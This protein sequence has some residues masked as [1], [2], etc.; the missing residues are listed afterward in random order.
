MELSR[1]EI[2]CEVSKTSAVFPTCGIENI[3]LGTELLGEI[4]IFMSSGS[5]LKHFIPESKGHENISLS[6]ILYSLLEYLVKESFSV[7]NKPL[8]AL[9]EVG[10]KKSSGNHPF[11]PDNSS[12]IALPSTFGSLGHSAHGH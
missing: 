11:L 5:I 10:N 9:L 2:I 3:C 4:A 8:A 6:M 7:Q 12:G 1:T